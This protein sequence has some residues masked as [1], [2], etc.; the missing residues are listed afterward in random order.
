VRD[1]TLSDEAAAYDAAFTPHREL[2]A[3]R[4]AALARELD[5]WLSAGTFWSGPNEAFLF[6]PA[7]EALVQRKLHPVPDEAACGMVTGD[8]IETID[9]DGLRCGVAICYDAEFPE[10]ARAFAERGAEVLLVP[11]FTS[12]PRGAG[13][14]AVCARARAVENQLFCVVTPLGGRAGVGTPWECGG[15][16]DP[17]VCAPIDDVF[18]EPSGILAHAGQDQAFCLAELDRERLERSRVAGEVPPWRDR[19]PQLYARL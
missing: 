18:P 12:T 15:H 11:S 17:L 16:G 13:R 4:A 8:A 5:V 2:F 6:G 7:G 14:V 19:R 10:V 1:V 3:E 9:V